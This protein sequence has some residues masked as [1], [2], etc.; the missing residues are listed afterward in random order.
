MEIAWKIIISVFLNFFFLISCKYEIE[1]LQSRRKVNLIYEVGYSISFIAIL[2][3]LIIY[4]YFRWVQFCNL[5]IFRLVEVVFARW[6]F[7]KE[8]LNIFR[9]AN[10]WMV[11]IGTRRRQPTVPKI[12]IRQTATDSLSFCEIPLKLI[13]ISKQSLWSILST[14]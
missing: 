4:S 10:A 14:H 7:S 13:V 8:N 2:L 1:I 5:S 9:G 12:Y 3:S 6:A 11:P